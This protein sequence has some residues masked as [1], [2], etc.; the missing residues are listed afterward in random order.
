MVNS[1]LPDFREIYLLLDV[2]AI[3]TAPEIRT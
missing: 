1:L 3:K 2:M